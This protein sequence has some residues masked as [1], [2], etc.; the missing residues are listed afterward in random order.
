MSQL[1]KNTV[2]GTK[3][4][5]DNEYV[6]IE[7]IDRSENIFPHKKIMFVG[8]SITMHGV[9]PQIGWNECYGMAASKKENDY[10]HVFMRKFR[11]FNPNASFCICQ[12]C[13]WESNYKNGETKYSLYDNAREFE[14]DII[15]MRAIENCPEKDFDNEIFKKEY[16]KLIRFLNVNNAKIFVTTSFW[17]HIGDDA[18]RE[19]AKEN[20]LPL[21][22]LGDLG[23]DDRM[24]AIGMFEHEGVAAHPG[25]LGMETMANRI[26]DAVKEFM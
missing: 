24:K 26:F 16:D 12:V 11:E 1:A 14:A 17:H 3:Q 6:K 8:N 13:E 20:N 23:E 5:K 22:V 2:K 21:I 25:D 9:A 7:Y 15:I 4:L 19:Y 18:I 10:V